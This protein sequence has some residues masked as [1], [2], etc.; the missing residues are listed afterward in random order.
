M[1]SVF[2]RN[3]PHRTIFAKRLLWIE[4]WKMSRCNLHLP[5]STAPSTFLKFPRKSLFPFTYISRKNDSLI[6]FFRSI[7]LLFASSFF[8]NSQILIRK[9]RFIYIFFFRSSRF[10]FD[11]FRIIRHFTKKGKSFRRIFVFRW[12][13]VEFSPSCCGRTG[14]CI[15]YLSPI[16]LLASFQNISKMFSKFLTFL[17]SFQQVF[18]KFVFQ[19]SPSVHIFSKFFKRWNAKWTCQ[20]IIT[21]W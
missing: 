20:Q 7:S 5:P 14:D 9:C 8:Q 10:L 2:C 17:Q 16:P 6:I 21:K 19:N 1:I 13:I 12:S 15:S 4:I 18:P 3:R 11:I